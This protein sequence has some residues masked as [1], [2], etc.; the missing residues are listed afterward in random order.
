MLRWTAVVLLA[1]ALALS[2]G[3]R[4]EEREL[5]PTSAA[6]PQSAELGWQERTPETGPGLVFRV[7]RFAVTDGGW[8]ANVEIENRTGIAWELGADRVAVSQSFGVMLFETGDLDEVEKRGR[9]GELPGLRPVRTF[10]PS[11]PSRLV[12]GRR[13]RSTISADGTL[14]AGRHLRIVFGRLV[15]D[16]DPPDGL[17]AQFVWI[18]DHAYRLHP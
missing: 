5:P 11:V 16:G 13:W 7:H 14:A 12:P 1:V 15:A 6:A 3:C 17:P 10:A 18:T 8:V 2:S 4:S 9:D